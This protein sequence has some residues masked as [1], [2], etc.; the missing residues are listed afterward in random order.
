M[1]W[2]LHEAR[3][4]IKEG[5]DTM[6]EYGEKSFNPGTLYVSCQGN[7]G[8]DNEPVSCA[9]R[10]LAQN[11]LLAAYEEPVTVKEICVEHGVSAIDV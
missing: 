1:K 11:I 8:R 4:F 10:K 9:K 6:R 3:T 5:M 2:W 7:L